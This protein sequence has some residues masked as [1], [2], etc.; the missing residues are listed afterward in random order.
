V[1]VDWQPQDIQH[2]EEPTV[3]IG[4]T[5]NY[6]HFVLEHIGRMASLDHLPWEREQ[7]R[8]LLPSTLKDYQREYLDLLGVPENRWLLQRPGVE[9]R[10]DQLIA[11][12]PL[13]RGSKHIHPLVPRWLRHALAPHPWVAAKR[14]FFLPRSSELLRTLLNEKEVGTLLAQHGF[15]IIRPE[16]LSVAGQIALFAQASV[17]VAPSGAALTNIVYMPPGGTVIVL[18]SAFTLASPAPL[19]FD[20]LSR[21][22]GHNFH[23]VAGTTDSFRTARAVDADFSVDLGLLN[24]QLL[25]LPGTPV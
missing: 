14:R 6:Y 13:V 8:W 22:C 7:L 16:T 23:T 11:P 20:E 17:V 18:Y 9:Y 12:L 24:T 21:A 25:A 19:Y 4:G 10:F 1:I 15:E 5:D 3:L 2:I